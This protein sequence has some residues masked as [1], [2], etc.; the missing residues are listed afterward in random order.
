MHG[1]IKQLITQW[2]AGLAALCLLTP[3]ALG[4]SDLPREQLPKSWKSDAELTDVFF[5][6]TRLGWAVG[7]QGTIVR[8]SDGGE[9]WIQ[10]SQRI[11]LSVSNLSLDQKLRNMRQGIQTRATGRAN[12]QSINPISC[13]FES[14]FFADEKNGWIAGGYSVPY[15]NRSKAIV[16]RTRD[17]GIT[18]NSV[19]HLV[20]PR[21][22]QIR[23]TD[24]LNGWAVG[25]A[26]NLFQSGIFYTSDGGQSWSSQT[27]KKIH[28]W[29]AVERTNDG[30]VTI[31]EAGQ[32]GTLRPNQYEQSVVI[33]E[34]IP[35]LSQV[36]MVN[37]ESGWAVGESGTLLNTT[38]GGKSWTQINLPPG[39][40]E[41]DL[42]TISV[43]GNQIWFAGDP[44]TVIY[45]MDTETGQTTSYRTPIRMRINQ[46]RFLDR[47]H[48]W[49]VGGGGAIIATTDGGQN[50]H[51]QRGNQQR[52]AILCVSLDDQSLPLELLAKYSIE[53][54]QTAAA[55]VV[56]KTNHQNQDLTQATERLGSSI[57]HSLGVSAEVDLSSA[58]TREKIV[59]K[60]TRVI[61]TM[62]PN[63]VVL[64][65]TQ[66]TTRRM[67][68][69][70]AE[71][72]S[73]VNSAI[74]QA[75]SERSFPVQITE[76]GLKTWKV[77]RFAFEDPTGDFTIDATRLLPRA[78]VL[79]EDQIALSRALL[80]KSVTS[81]R[82]LRY[83]VNHLSQR[84]RMQ[85]GNLLSGLDKRKIASPRNMTD[86][87]RGNLN[88]IQQANAKQRKVEEFVR[89][90]SVSP[91]DLLIWRQQ[92]QAFTMPMDKGIA[93]VWL[94]QLAERYLE[95]GKTELAAQTNTL[96]VNH[97]ADHAFAP[98]AMNW[99]AKY[100]SSEE[101]AQI[102]YR[103]KIKNG[104]LTDHGTLTETQRLKESYQPRTQQQF[105][106]GSS[107]IKW[108][109][110]DAML[111]SK[112]KKSPP[113][114]EESEAQ[115][116][117]TPAPIRP[118]FFDQRLQIASK[119]LNQMKQRDPE[120]AAGPQYKFMETH[121]SRRLNGA[122]TNEGRYKSLAQ[123]GDAEKVGISIAAQ[124]EL[125][126]SPQLATSSPR[127][128]TG[129]CRFTDKPP[130]LDGKLDEPFW[131]NGF[132]KHDAWQMPRST[133]NSGSKSSLDL[134]MFAYDDKYF[135][136]GFQCQKIAGQ[137]Y[138]T[139]N[140][141]RPRDA[142][143]THR[144]RIEFSID[145]DRDYL[146]QNCFVIDHRGWVKESCSG[147][148]GW[149][150][151]WFVS[152]SEDEATWTIEVAIPLSCLVPE[153]IAAN[154]TVWAL[155]IARRGYE[156]T[157]LWHDS[158]TQPFASSLP[159]PMGIRNTLQAR[160]NDF[161]L[162]KFISQT[163]ETVTKLTL[164][165]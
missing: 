63:V 155:K 31:N 97:W 81:D 117:I 25:E 143:L 27:S 139:P 115:E 163:P 39:A 85:A 158:T 58:T 74:T 16:M 111:K 95:V 44:G 70:S 93:G 152:Q 69:L 34:K 129:V 78:G 133:A 77:D 6:N 53:E 24:A 118:A 38:N 141:S 90:E 146:S 150:P 4:D 165:N 136:A 102:E 86:A 22:Q 59:Q 18:W 76:L 23:F 54:N 157:N 148:L 108:L 2:G 72:F 28:S 66:P 36:R 89:F 106:N 103:N 105:A 87:K 113:K 99:L 116:T 71:L 114:D 124:R 91:R 19:E 29:L 45:S 32:L 10:I 162:L 73:L 159:S 130:K 149:N 92:I 145:V 94:M 126:L 98:A 68:Q 35:T 135:Y 49:A 140:Q 132:Q 56:L 46:L 52:V 43:V 17:G 156:A 21:F 51:V 15:I 96:L 30:L 122:L 41:I 67:N 3:L 160:P 55:L 20:A 112:E 123:L 61:R 64:N 1:F 11:N 164:G 127:L 26:G 161:E 107:Q 101:F 84:E 62:Q 33:S 80:G 57:L 47:L 154:E 13:R 119:I 144:D 128:K 121:I 138:K 65:S 48:G 8:T 131:Q 14:V 120:F 134:A 125:A 82:V 109:P 40:S 147:S 137:S 100:Y 12:G 60:L 88:M 110:S 75:G 9:T 104:E 50:W 42:E 153:K 83:R 5:L 37:N 7:A 79:I 142:D 151:N